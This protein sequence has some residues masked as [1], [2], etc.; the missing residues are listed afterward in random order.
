[1]EFG[2]KLLG[3]P[4]ASA[5]LV[6]LARCLQ[7]PTLTDGDMHVLVS[8]FHHRLQCQLAISTFLDQVDWRSKRPPQWDFSGGGGKAEREVVEGDEEAEADAWR[9]YFCWRPEVAPW[10]NLVWTDIRQQLAL[11]WGAGKPSFSR[12]HFFGCRHADF[13]PDN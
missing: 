13:F 2:V 11:A 7:K 10:R 12:A 9:E 4:I 1:M 3:A 6:Y 5:H 8:A